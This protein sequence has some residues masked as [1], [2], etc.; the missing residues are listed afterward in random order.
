MTPT[1]RTL[2]RVRDN[3]SVADVVERWI[4]IPHHP[5]GGVRK[6]MLGFID[7]VELR[8][9]Q[10]VGI[11]CTSGSN[12]SKRVIKIKTECREAAIAWINTGARI[13]VWGW[14]E[15]K[16]KVNRKSWQARIVELGLEDLV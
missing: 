10:I 8:D 3:G 5:G 16:K 12:H 6:D 7:I 2:K 14:R 9:E 11:Q 1:Q 4:P 15:L 13:E